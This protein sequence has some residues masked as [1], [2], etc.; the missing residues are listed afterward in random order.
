[1]DD[2]MFPSLGA[3]EPCFLPV[4]HLRACCSCGNQKAA[5]QFCR[6][7]HRKAEPQVYLGLDP[8]TAQHVAGG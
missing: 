7:R 5:C 2:S 8:S 6:F 4:V 3:P 1:M